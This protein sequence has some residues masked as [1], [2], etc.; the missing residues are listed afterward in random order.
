M[1]DGVSQDVSYLQLI[2]VSTYTY[3]YSDTW[4]HPYV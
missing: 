4:I 3:A 2:D 1:K